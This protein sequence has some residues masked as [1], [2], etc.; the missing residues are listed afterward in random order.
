MRIVRMNGMLL[1]RWRLLA[2]GTVL[3]MAASCGGSLTSAQE[4]GPASDGAPTDTSTAST[5]A[6]T[7]SPDAITAPPDTTG[8]VNVDA[9]CHIQ[10]SSYDQT[11]S[12]DSDCVEMAGGFSIDFG[13]DYCISSCMCNLDS[14]NK[15]STAQFVSDVSRTPLGS[16]AIPAAVCNCPGSPG[17]PCCRGGTCTVRCP[18]LDSGPGIVWDA[19]A[20]DGSTPCPPLDAGG[21]ARWCVTDQQC[22]MFNGGWACCL[23]LGGMFTCN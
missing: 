2:A 3:I 17:G 19:A 14:I 16:G 11:C 4:G 10:A 12:V 1:T 22:L 21:P 13:T 8:G 20:L 18:P 15:N 6:T 23:H 9:A 7:A 5:D